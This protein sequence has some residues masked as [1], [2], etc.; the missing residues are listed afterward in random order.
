MDIYKSSMALLNFIRVHS[1][2]NFEFKSY[3]D[4]EILRPSND[5]RTH[6]DIYEEYGGSICEIEMDEL[7]HQIAQLLMF[8]QYYIV[9]TKLLLQYVLLSE[10]KLSFY[11]YLFNFKIHVLLKLNCPKILYSSTKE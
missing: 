7:C 1:K 4:D 5:E 6:E 3:D 11:D 2:T 8:S 9:L 10:I